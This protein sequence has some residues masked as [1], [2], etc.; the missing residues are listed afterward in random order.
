MNEV[1]LVFLIELPMIV[2]A[3]VS[4]WPNKVKRVPYVPRYMAGM[5]EG[6]KNII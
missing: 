6:A 4:V 2:C 3:I 1:L 5:I